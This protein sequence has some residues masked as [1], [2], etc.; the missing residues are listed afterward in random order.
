MHVLSNPTCPPL[1]CSFVPVGISRISA[2][3]LSVK[4]SVIQKVRSLCEHWPL[5]LVMALPEKQGNIYISKVTVKY[6]LRQFKTVHWGIETI[7]R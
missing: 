6:I 7:V 2:V 5:D 1:H 3:Y 4:L